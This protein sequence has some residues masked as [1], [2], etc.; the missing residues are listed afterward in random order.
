MSVSLIRFKNMVEVEDAVKR[1]HFVEYK[2]AKD[3]RGL[4]FE[5][6]KLDPRVVKVVE[7]ADAKA[8]ATSSNREPAPAKA[9]RAPRPVKTDGPVHRIRDWARANPDATPADAVAHFADLHP[10]TVKIQLR[11]VR[12]GEV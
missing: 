10:A 11:K 4:Y 12:K 3:E 8:R 6:Y 7:E 1:C 5:S 2:V 9:E